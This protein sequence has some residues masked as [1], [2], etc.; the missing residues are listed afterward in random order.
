[1]NGKRNP[2]EGVNLLSFINEKR[3]KEAVAEHAPNS[4]LS[5]EEI[6]RNSHG[7]EYLFQYDVSVQDT[8][9]AQHGNKEA[10]PDIVAC[11]CRWVSSNC[12]PYGPLMENLLLDFVVA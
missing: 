11:Q 3:L 9:V 10:F 12:R 6:A 1:M 8:A 5:E 7:K 4:T 2:W